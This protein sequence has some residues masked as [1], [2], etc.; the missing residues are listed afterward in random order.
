MSKCHGHSVSC[1]FVFDEA[2]WALFA[3]PSLKRENFNKKNIP[4]YQHVADAG[5]SGLVVLAYCLVSGGAGV[6]LVTSR[7]LQLNRLTALAAAPPALTRAAALLTDMTVIIINMVIT[8]VLMAAFHFPVFV[9]GNNLPAICLLILLYGFACSGLMQVAERRFSDAGVASMVLFC[10]NAMLGLGGITV[11][12]ILDLISQSDATDDARWVLHKIFLV[13]P[14]FALGDGLLEIA[15]NTIQ[16]QVLSRFGMD[17]YKDPLSSSLVGLHYLYLVLVG[18]ALFLLNLALDYQCFDFLLNKLYPTPM[19]DPCDGELEDLDVAAERRRVLEAVSRTRDTPLRL[20][21][22][23]NINAGFVD[24]E[25]KKTESLSRAHKDPA[26]GPD[27][28]WCVG[29]GKRYRGRKLPALNDLTLALPAGQCTAL[30]GVNGAGK[31]TTFSLLTGQ[32]RPTTGHIY[33]QG[34]P[35]NRRQLCQGYIMSIAKDISVSIAKDKSDSIAKDI[36]VISRTVE[37]FE[38]GRYIDTRAGNLSGGNKRK[39]CAAIALMSRAPLVLLDEPTSGMDPISRACVWR[40]VRA[41]CGVRRGVLL[42][43]HVPQ[44]ARRSCRSA[45]VLHAA[46]L[47]RLR[48]LH[49][50]NG[51]CGGYVV[52]C[53]VGQGAVGR[54]WDAVRALQPPA[55]LLLTHTRA[56][57]VMLPAT[58]TVDGK[59]TVMRLSDVFRL[60]ARLQGACDIEDYAVTQPELDQMFLNLDDKVRIE[61]E[62]VDLEPLPSP[63]ALRP[64]R[65]Q[66]DSVTAL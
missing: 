9:W 44:D 13:A 64:D 7:R 39:L 48:P 41:A 20:H 38:L 21:T 60:M 27:V 51:L 12:L 37:T 50:L 34:K 16:A 22:I 15:K 11:L 4:R 56:L 26:M 53:V 29:L 19:P 59:E 46:R 47:R 57:R 40:A 23:G 31:S 2:V 65:D 61:D 35:A 66:L 49:A 52:E 58:Y 6:Y 30:L 14:P 42:A 17:T 18:T 10:M 1:N 28:A 5:I 45:A 33:V 25:G 32:L 54:V 36:S 62:Y 43:T 63:T 3:L 24:T 55:R 8:A